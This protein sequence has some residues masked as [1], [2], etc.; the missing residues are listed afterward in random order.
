[1]RAP[2]LLISALVACNGP[3]VDPAGDAPGARPP[4][5]GPDAEPGPG[6][7]GGPVPPEEDADP[8]RPPA[9]LTGIDGTA[10]ED[11]DAAKVAAAMAAALDQ[12]DPAGVV[13]LMAPAMLEDDGDEMFEDLAD[14]GV[15]LDLGETRYLGTRDGHHHY[16]SSLT[17]EEDAQKQQ[18]RFHM[19]L[20]QV[21][22]AWKVLDLNGWPVDAEGKPVVEEADAATPPPGAAEAE[23]PA[24]PAGGG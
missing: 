13:A 1:M 2:L 21:D 6:Q 17:V 14:N 24:P 22:G 5:A 19:E 12:E 4:A 18:L 15:K 8:G 3:T 7:P 20:G 11:P 23:A 16:L 9:D 10:T